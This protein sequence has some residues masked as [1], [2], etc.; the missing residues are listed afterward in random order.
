MVDDPTYSGGGGGGGPGSSWAEMFLPADRK[1]EVCF[2]EALLGLRLLHK[3]VISLNVSHD[4]LARADGFLSAQSEYCSSASARQIM[5]PCL[6]PQGSVPVR[7]C[8]QFRR[9]WSACVY[10]LSQW[11]LH[12]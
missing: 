4:L 9:D 5:P 6:L 12:S 7:L 11:L 2:P 3:T 1:P 8:Y 10:P